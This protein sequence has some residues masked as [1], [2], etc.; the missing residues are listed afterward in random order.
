M[1]EPR[2][3]FLDA[4]FG[5]ALP[6]LAGAPRADGSG[7][8]AESVR[9][10]AAPIPL[11]PPRRKLL[12]GL[13]LLWHD[14]LDAAHA[15]AQ[16][17]EGQPDHDLLH[18]ML[19]RREGDYPNSEYWFRSAGRHPSHAALEREAS[20]LLADGDPLRD[21]L[22]PSGRWS[23]R[24]FVAEARAA[25]GGKGASMALLERLQALE[26]RAFAGWLLGN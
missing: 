9:S 13:A 16:G 2:Q 7:L 24:A 21:R 15:V 20:A 4:L 5:G 8:S 26:F 6:S 23:S 1:D 14:H 25:A 12:E 22:L 10:L 17:H 18:A 3:D 19:H 11:P